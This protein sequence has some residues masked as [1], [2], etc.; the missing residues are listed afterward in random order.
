[1]TDLFLKNSEPEA[2]NDE[3]SIDDPTEEDEE[4]LDDGGFGDGIDDDEDELE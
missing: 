3:I 2:D 1:M 4:I